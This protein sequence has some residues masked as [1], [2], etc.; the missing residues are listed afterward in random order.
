MDD[1]REWRRKTTKADAKARK[2]ARYF[3]GIECEDGHVSDRYVKNDKCVQCIDDAKLVKFQL[4][5][6]EIARR[7]E[8][9]RSG[10]K[11]DWPD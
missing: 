8:R 10:Y 9:F 1:F 4:E 6:E 7:L 3:N 11:V 5:Q 2:K